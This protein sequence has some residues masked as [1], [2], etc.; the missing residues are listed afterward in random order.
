MLQNSCEMLIIEEIPSYSE[1]IDLQ[2]VSIESTSVEINVGDK[3][4][5]RPATLNTTKKPPT[6]I[7]KMFSS[8]LAKTQNRRQEK[9]RKEDLSGEMEIGEMEIS[10]GSYEEKE[11]TTA[12]AARPKIRRTPP[13][14]PDEGHFDEE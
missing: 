2:N 4:Q 7:A 1:E 12:F 14:L 5:N 11:Y 13:K 8:K 10:R 3:R 9:P 6:E